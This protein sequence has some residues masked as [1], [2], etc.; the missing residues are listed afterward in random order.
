MQFAHRNTFID[1]PPQRTRMVKGIA[2][3]APDHADAKLSAAA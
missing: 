3:R 1:Y 2:R